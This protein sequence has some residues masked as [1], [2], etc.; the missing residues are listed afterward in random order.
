MARVAFEIP[1]IGLVMQAVK[2]QRWLK[3]V[4]DD[5]K[6]GEPL[7]EVETEKSVVEIEAAFGGKLVEILMPVGAEANVGDR[8]AWFEADAAAAAAAPAMAA[9]TATASAPTAAAPVLVPPIAAAPSAPATVPTLPATAP[10]TRPAATGERVRSSPVARRVA[11]EHGV[12]LA[13]VAGS[14]PRGRVQL[15]DV[16]AAVAA[17]AAGTAPAAGVLPPMRRALARAMMLSA[18][19]VPQFTLE[20]AVDMTTLQ[21]ARAALSLGLPAGTPK[22][23]VTDFLMQAV[24]GALLEFPALNATFAGDPASPDARIVPA[25]GAHIGLVLAVENGLL[26]PVIHGVEKLGLAELARRRSDCVERGLAGRLGREEL[27]GA[28]FSISNLGQD[29]PD[30][31]AA[32]INPPQSAILAVGRQRDC[33][34][35][36]DGAVVIRP[37]CEL[38]LTVDH[39]VAD[40]RLAAEF[41][42]SLCGLLEGESWLF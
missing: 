19:T 38:T 17:R 30:R 21:A 13:R 15:A 2:L 27:E 5:V 14:G 37:I 26:V 29:G 39:R 33:V 16:R 32:I 6:V 42:T 31:F 18:A 9:A 40:G 20:R 10:L 28:T 24:A 8:V 11:L 12:E 34:V 25:S 4:G 22:L 7:L 36:R 1:K 35:V 41:L 3:D 23:S